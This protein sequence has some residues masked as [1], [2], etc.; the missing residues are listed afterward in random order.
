M[1]VNGPGK[2][3]GLLMV[4]WTFLLHI[5]NDLLLVFDLK[6]KKSLTPLTL[7]TMAMEEE[8]GRPKRRELQ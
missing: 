2:R 4:Y 5:V 8:T 3:L 1:K 6:K 7:N